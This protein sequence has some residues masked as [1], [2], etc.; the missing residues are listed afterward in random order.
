[1][2]LAIQIYEN[3]I[4]LYESPSLESYHVSTVLGI[5]KRFKDII[6]EF[7]NEIKMGVSFTDEGDTYKY[8]I[9]K[10]VISKSNSALE[11]KEWLTPKLHSI[12]S[13][14]SKKDCLSVIESM[15]YKFLRA[16]NI[17][18]DVRIHFNDGGMISFNPSSLNI[19]YGRSGELNLGSCGSIV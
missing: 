4:G 8:F 10:Y 9:G 3:A 18:R 12:L 6:E 16:E 19:S 5:L 7:P 2:Q 13:T 15:E 1:M 14:V 11:F 17:T